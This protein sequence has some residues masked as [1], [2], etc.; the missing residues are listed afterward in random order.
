MY[1]QEQIFEQ[2]SSFS[3]IQRLVDFYDELE[4]NLNPQLDKRLNDIASHL[5]SFYGDCR[6]SKG[7]EEL[8]M[9]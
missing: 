4:E 6:I 8:Q 5:F 9:S 1:F 2:V 3:Y 7:R